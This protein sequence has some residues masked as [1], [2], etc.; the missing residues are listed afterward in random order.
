MVPRP[1]SAGDNPTRSAR[2]FF[3]RETNLPAGPVTTTACAPA[4]ELAARCPESSRIGRVTASS[5]LGTATGALHFTGLRG[6]K[7]RGVLF[8]QGRHAP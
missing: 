2:L 3:P 8:L 4:D 6:N 5:P 7:I 1:P